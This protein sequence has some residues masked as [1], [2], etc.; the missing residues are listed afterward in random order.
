M[1]TKYANDANVDFRELK[2]C[3]H[4]DC[5]I[6][7]TSLRTPYTL[8]VALSD[9]VRTLAPDDPNART[10]SLAFTMPL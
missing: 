2:N 3:G 8:A 10:R 7:D 4:N 6:R 9:V 5:V 1:G